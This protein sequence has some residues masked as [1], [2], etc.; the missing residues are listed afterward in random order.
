MKDFQNTPEASGNLSCRRTAP[1][2][3]HYRKTTHPVST[4]SS[5]A[6]EKRK[7]TQRQLLQFKWT[8]KNYCWLWQAWRNI[9]SWTCLQEK[10]LP[11]TMCGGDTGHFMTESEGPDKPV[12]HQLSTFQ[13]HHNQTRTNQTDD[14]GGGGGR[15]KCLTWRKATLTI[16]TDSTKLA[17][18]HQHAV[19]QGRNSLQ[20]KGHN[21]QR[22]IKQSRET[23]C[24]AERD[25]DWKKHQ[26]RKLL[27]RHYNNG[28]IL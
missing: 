16:N 11:E 15:L 23:V 13:P 20:C 12:V 18:A 26:K 17:S 9:H 3:T 14:P 21:D 22:T 4:W 28:G 5:F 7:K 19:R 24:E 25:A 6:K 1:W 8:C 2:Q 27:L 10:R